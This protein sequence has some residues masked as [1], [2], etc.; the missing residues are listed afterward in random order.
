M[1][2]QRFQLVT[3]AN[4]L[5]DDCR[6][7]F[8]NSKEPGARAQMM[9]GNAVDVFILNVHSIAGTSVTIGNDGIINLKTDN[10]FGGLVNMVVRPEQSIYTLKKVKEG[11]LLSS[12]HWNLL[13]YKGLALSTA[14]DT[15][16]VT[17]L[18]QLL[19][20]AQLLEVTDTTPGIDL[21]ISLNSKNEVYVNSGE[22]E[23]SDVL[24][25]IKVLLGLGD[26]AKRPFEGIRDCQES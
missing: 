16:G 26:I 6:Y 4:Q 17:D 23:L 19:G 2:A 22:T 9:G 7:I 8:V 25:T 15:T 13:N 21:T 1:L 10:I 12:V 24:G 18:T 3:D 14:R 5:E 11:G 20:Q